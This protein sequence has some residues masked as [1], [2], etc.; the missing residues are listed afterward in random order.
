MEDTP[1]TGAKRRKPRVGSCGLR[2]A[3][4]TEVHTVRERLA[5]LAPLALAEREATRGD[6]CKGA[7]SAPLAGPLASHLAPCVVETDDRAPRD[8]AAATFYGAWFGSQ[9][10][11]GRARPVDDRPLATGEATGFTYVAP[12][13]TDGPALVAMALDAI[14][15]TPYLVRWPGRERS[16][17]RRDC[18]DTGKAHAQDMKCCAIACARARKH[19]Q[20]FH[21]APKTR[22]ITDYFGDVRI[23]GVHPVTG[24]LMYENGQLLQG[25]D[26]RSSRDAGP[27][28]DRTTPGE[29]T[30]GPSM[31]V[32]GQS[33]RIKAQRVVIGITLTR[34]WY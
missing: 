32:R 7:P 10:P 16:F 29:A 19:S 13:E 2:R 24:E 5:P 18:T 14:D 15:T 3:P 9:G 1:K 6:T 20:C 34:I 22:K 23:A 17:T 31:V 25:K 8:V 4:M 21:V 27:R 30:F 33:S 12:E 11:T 26:P 28:M